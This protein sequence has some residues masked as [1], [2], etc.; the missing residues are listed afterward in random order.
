[1]EYNRMFFFKITGVV[2]IH[3]YYCIAHEWAA[4]V[5]ILALVLFYFFHS[6]S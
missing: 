2:L 4:D 3:T 6:F 5:F 1:M